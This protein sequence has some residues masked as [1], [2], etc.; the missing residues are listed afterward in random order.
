MDNGNFTNVRLD[1]KEVTVDI[2]KDLIKEV[3]STDKNN[4]DS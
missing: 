3:K 4:T 2:L 1:D